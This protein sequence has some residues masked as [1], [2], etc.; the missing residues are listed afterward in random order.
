MLQSELIGTP[1]KY[2][3]LLTINNVYP[4]N[5]RYIVTKLDIMNSK[6]C[7]IFTLTFCFYFSVDNFVSGKYILLFS[8]AQ[9]HLPI[10]VPNI[11]QEWLKLQYFS[12]FVHS[13][14]CGLELKSFI[15]VRKYEKRLINTWIYEVVLSVIKIK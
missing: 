14:I 5:K 13:G 10:Q 12:I 6:E 11:S 1:E 7:I 15:I 3:N 9:V 2:S 4:S 8:H